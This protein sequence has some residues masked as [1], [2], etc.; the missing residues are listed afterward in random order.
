MTCPNI[1]KKM[2]LRKDRGTLRIR[3]LI[4][5]SKI[6]PNPCPGGGEMRKWGLHR[7]GKDHVTG[8]QP[9]SIKETAC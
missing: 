3:Q 9:P 8:A 7:P 1:Y 4:T 2:E 6:H 5:M